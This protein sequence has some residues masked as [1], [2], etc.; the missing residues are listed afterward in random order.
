MVECLGDE[1]IEM[2]WGLCL[3]YRYFLGRVFFIWC[4]E[5]SFVFFIVV[6]R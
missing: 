3:G 4:L 6:I 5:S 1:G 2:G